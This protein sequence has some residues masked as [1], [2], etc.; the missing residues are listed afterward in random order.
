MAKVDRRQAI[1][2][3]VA[4]ALAT[5][6]SEMQFEGEHVTDDEKEIAKEAMAIFVA[7]YPAGSEPT[8][9]QIV[10]KGKLAIRAW[11]LLFKDS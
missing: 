6:F 3:A 8:K 1:T 7:S 11:R 10:E 4:A 5:L 9:E 2:I